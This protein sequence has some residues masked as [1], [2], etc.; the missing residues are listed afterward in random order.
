M[1]G[2]DAAQGDDSMTQGTYTDLSGA[3]NNLQRDINGVGR[4]VVDVD[5]K[6]QQV[7][8]ETAMARTDV[9]ELREAFERYVL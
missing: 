3:L 8:Q 6:V 9:S 7:G 1:P 5:T 4:M 2:S